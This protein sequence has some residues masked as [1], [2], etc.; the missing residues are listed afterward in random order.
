M[1]GGSYLRQN[2]NDFTTRVDGTDRHVDTTIRYNAHIHATLIRPIHERI[3]VERIN[4]FVT[5][6]YNRVLYTIPWTL[7]LL[8]FI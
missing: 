2:F 1:S 4:V 5:E 7:H 3:H 8:A 6:L